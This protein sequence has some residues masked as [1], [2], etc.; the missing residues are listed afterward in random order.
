MQP[1]VFS[2][3]QPSGSP[4][5]GNFLGAIRNWAQ[6]QDR[7]DNI[8]CVVD[9]HALTQPQDPR[10]LRQH[11]WEIAAILLAAG[12]D[13]DRSLLFAQSHVPEHTTLAWLLNTITPMGWLKASVALAL[14][15][16]EFEREFRA[17]L[18]T[19]DH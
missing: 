7:F 10:E 1:R 11:T 18:G 19:L 5:L 15:R 12:I 17:W 16:P 3:I 14:Q 2:G 4:T 13:P 9:L 6:G 8:F